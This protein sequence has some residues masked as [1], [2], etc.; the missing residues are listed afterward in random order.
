MEEQCHDILKPALASALPAMGIN[1]HFPQAVTHGPKSHQGLDIPNLFMEQWCTH[2]LMI[3]HFGLQPNDLTGL[4]IN[5]NAEA[6]CLKA[7]LDDKSSMCHSEY[8]CI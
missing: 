7:S 8:M 4:L 5:A 3:L 1:R 2:I 6:F